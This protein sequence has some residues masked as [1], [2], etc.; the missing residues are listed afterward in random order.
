MGIKKIISID[1]KYQESNQYRAFTYLWM[2]VMTRFI[3]FWIIGGG[4]VAI[5]NNATLVVKH[6]Q[7][8]VFIFYW[9]F[10]TYN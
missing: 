6:Q 8:L 2:S 3:M 5:L 4:W 1:W 10:D 9:H 7:T